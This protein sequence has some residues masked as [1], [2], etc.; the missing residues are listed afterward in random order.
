MLPLITHFLAVSVLGVMGVI[1]VAVGF[2]GYV[3]LDGDW[4]SGCEYELTQLPKVERCPECGADLSARGAVMRDEIKEKLAPRYIG[5]GLLML[6]AAT[7][8]LFAPLR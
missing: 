8:L 6:I 7:V 2:A 4:C 5:A 1:C 3:Q